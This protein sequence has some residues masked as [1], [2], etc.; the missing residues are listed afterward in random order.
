VAYCSRY[1]AAWQV[2]MPVWE[3]APRPRLEP[4]SAPRQAPEPV[5]EKAPE[6]LPAREPEPGSALAAK[7][8]LL[9]R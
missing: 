4:A 9:R 5:P 1:E 3:A 2:T 7:R 8:L 6:Q